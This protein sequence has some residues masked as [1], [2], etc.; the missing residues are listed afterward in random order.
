MG[1]GSR[2]VA[3]L[4]MFVFLGLGAW[5]VSLLLLLYVVYTSRK[6]RAKAVLVQ[7]QEVFQRPGPPWGRYVI[8]AFS[9]LFSL[10]ALEAG[11]TYSPAVFFAAGLAATFWPFLARSGLAGGVVPVKDSV[12]LRSRLFPFSWHALAEVKLESQGQTRGIA[13]MGGKILLFAGNAPALFQLITVHA[14]SY[15]QA[16][17]GV[18][19]ELRRKTRMLSQRGAHLIPADSADAGGRLSLELER[20]DVG[21]ED[22]DTVS[23]LPFEAA[24][25]KVKDGRLVSHRA[26]N[27]LE[28]NGQPTIPSPDLKHAREPLFAEVVQEVGEKHGWPPPDEFS[29]FLAALDASRSE[30]IADKIRMMGETAGRL[31]VETAGGAEVRLSRA[32]LR[33]LARIYG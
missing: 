27:I 20:L 23:S 28:Q 2:A 11:G 15:K 8:A 32:Q 7:K 13:S 26:F 31:A 12:L 22:F 16:E 29:P 5:P 25:F 14:L 17:A 9:F 33:V 10:V 21:T 18:V 4:L 19:K 6:P 1:R 30:P 24:V 3:V